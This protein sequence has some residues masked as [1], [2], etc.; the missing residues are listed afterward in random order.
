MKNAMAENSKRDRI[1]TLAKSR[2]VIR[3]RDLRDLGIDQ[4]YLH[5][6]FRAGLLEHVGR[7]LYSLRDSETS[8]MQSVVEV[9]TYAPSAII[10][11][12]SALSYHGI[13][14]Q[15]PPT[16]WIAIPHKAWAPRVPTVSTTVVRME[17][18]SLCGDV[19]THLIDGVTVRMT[20][21][22]RTV[23]NCW[24]FRSRVGLEAA[25]EALR[26]GLRKRLFTA[27]DLYVCAKKDR[28]WNVLRPYM[29]ATLQ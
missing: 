24:R 29:E 26:D 16:V 9:A 25:L 21:P 7:G 11:L 13:G 4:S 22:V 8:N 10:C 2:S 23:T 27:D 19:E 1:L 17:P 20:N 3:P 14:T 6:L 18:Q 12:L 5:V 15:L 28:V